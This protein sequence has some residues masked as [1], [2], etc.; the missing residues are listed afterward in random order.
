MIFLVTDSFYSGLDY[1]INQKYLFEKRFS[2][3][4]LSDARSRSESFQTEK[5]ERRKE[6]VNVH[7]L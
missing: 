1:S 6:R 2:R 5:D 3:E 7:V 4:A